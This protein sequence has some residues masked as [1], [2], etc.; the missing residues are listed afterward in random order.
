MSDPNAN[1]Y[2]ISALEKLNVH[3]D[4]YENHQN[5]RTLPYQSD[6]VSW[7]VIREE[8]HLTGLELAALQNARCFPQAG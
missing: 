2:F 6:A 1:A 4:D 8:Y 7:N 5:F 3:L